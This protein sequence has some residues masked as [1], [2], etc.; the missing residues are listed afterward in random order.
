MLENHGKRN[1]VRLLGLKET[2]GTNGTMEI[3]VKKVQKDGLGLDVDGEFEIERA[4]RVPA[5]VP[6]E[7]QPPRP[8]LIRFLPGSACSARLDPDRYCRE[9][10]SGSY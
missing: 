9:R 10:A 5:P 8:V 3:C 2:Y 1:N 7:N 6:N 4:H